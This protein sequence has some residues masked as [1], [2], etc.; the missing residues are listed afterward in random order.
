[1]QGSK[2]HTNNSIRRG[3]MTFAC[4]ALHAATGPTAEA[5]LA[6]SR[7]QSAATQETRNAPA[8]K[9]SVQLTHKRVKTNGITLHYVMAGRGPTV[10]CMHGWPQNHKEF[11]G[12]IEQL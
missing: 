2:V 4:T 12:I 8:A 10:L 1:M 11:V 9:N 5:A 3:A 6:Q 7:E